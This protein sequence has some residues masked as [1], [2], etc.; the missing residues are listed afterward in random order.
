MLPRLP[1]TPLLM[2]LH[3][4]LN[5]LN[6][7]KHDELLSMPSDAPKARTFPRAT[8]QYTSKV[9]SLVLCSCRLCCSSQQL[10]PTAGEGVCYQAMCAA[11]QHMHHCRETS[12]KAAACV[13]SQHVTPPSPADCCGR[14]LW[15][16][17]LVLV[18][19]NPVIP[20]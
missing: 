20:G 16:F 13:Y 8:C 17:V 15:C 14:C 1:H 2:A 6:S 19:L 7:H 11:V 12:S 9:R 10:A 4:L 3:L 5:V 18:L